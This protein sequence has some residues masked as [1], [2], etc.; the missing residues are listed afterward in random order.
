MTGNFGTR[1]SCEPTQLPLKPCQQDQRR[2][3]E[4]LRS[5]LAFMHIATPFLTFY[6]E[7]RRIEDAYVQGLRRLSRKQPPDAESELG[8][9][10]RTSHGS[11]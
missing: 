8:Y 6:Q 3:C 11:P 9:I 2:F 5:K 10:F 7:R 4:L 1:A